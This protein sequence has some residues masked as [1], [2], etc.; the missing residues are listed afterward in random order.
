[1]SAAPLGGRIGGEM[2]S[3]STSKTVTAPAVA[4]FW[5]ACDNI[6]VQFACK[7]GDSDEKSLLN[8]MVS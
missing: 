5:R 2:P 4:H 8:P 1:M 3:A 7:G 6:D